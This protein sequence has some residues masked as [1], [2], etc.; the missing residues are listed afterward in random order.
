MST[1]KDCPDPRIFPITSSWG[2]ESRRQVRN[3]SAT[4]P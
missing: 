1:H 4:F 3:E 2:L